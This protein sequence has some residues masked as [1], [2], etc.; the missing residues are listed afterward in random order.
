M[1]WDHGLERRRTQHTYWTGSSCLDIIQL[2]MMIDMIDMIY[3]SYVYIYCLYIICVTEPPTIIIQTLLLRFSSRF[4]LHHGLSLTQI[5]RSRSIDLY[6]Y[7][8]TYLDLQIY[9]FRQI[10]MCFTVCFTYRTQMISPIKKTIPKDPPI[11][12]RTFNSVGGKILQITGEMPYPF[13]EGY[14]WDM[15][16]SKVFIIG[17]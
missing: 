13:R 2:T 16:H 17:S 7:R 8:Y 9:L 1:R 10:Q 11:I 5:F 4:S 12:R 15:C 6:R 14:V 3:D